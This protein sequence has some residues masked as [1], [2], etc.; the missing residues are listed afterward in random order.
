MTHSVLI[1]NHTVSVIPW[2]CQTERWVVLDEDVENG[3][4]DQ[5]QSPGGAPTRTLEKGLFLLGLFDAEHPEWTLREL[6]ERAGLPKATTRRLVKTL[7][8]GGWVEYD[9]VSRTYHLGSSALKALYLATSH[10]ELA[11]FVHPFLVELEQETTESAIFSIWTEQG[12]LI[13]DSV[14]TS[15]SFKPLTYPGMFLPGVSSAD[16]QV[17]IA[18]GPEENWDRLLKKP[19]EPRT[20]RT[21][22]DPTLLRERWRTVR[23]EGIA[24]DWGEWN[25]DA[26]AVAAPVFDRNEH[27]RGAITVVPP[28]ERCSEEDMQRY[29]AAVRRTA[30]AISAKLG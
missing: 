26:P 13:L 29:A 4:E 19:I 22:T 9:P 15:R 3:T 23:R 30:A 7:E 14:P 10:P 6:R 8:A 17:L 5:T 12:P 27:L 11:R 1:M 28:E 21:V 16:A 2:S 18:F 20:S 24:Y 25:I